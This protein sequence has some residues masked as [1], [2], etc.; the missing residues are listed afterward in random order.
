[1]DGVGE[2]GGEICGGGEAREG[3]LGGVVAVGEVRSEANLLKR[4]YIYIYI[5]THTHTH[6]L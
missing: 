1:M 5:H 3:E 6:I 2:E 4:P